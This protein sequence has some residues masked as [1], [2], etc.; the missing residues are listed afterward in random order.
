MLVNTCPR[1]ESKFYT[2][3][4]FGD[5]SCPFCGFG[6]KFTDREMRGAERHSIQ[7][8]CTLFA[9]N[10]ESKLVARTFDISRTGVGVCVE[11]AFPFYVGA[12]LNVVIDPLEINSEAKVVWVKRSGPGFSKAGLQ[13][14]K[15]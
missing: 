2:A 15:A 4:T 14:F 5:I 9:D 7:K 10:A 1:C 8:L 13:F 3:I 11:S 6:I 12:V